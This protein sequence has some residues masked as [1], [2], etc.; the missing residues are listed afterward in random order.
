[1]TLAAVLALFLAA[2]AGA[3]FA[4]AFVAAAARLGG[5]ADEGFL[6]VLMRARVEVSRVARGM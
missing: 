1:M 2:A 6:I 4:A 5:M 3:S